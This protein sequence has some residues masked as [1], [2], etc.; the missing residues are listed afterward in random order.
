[1]NIIRLYRFLGSIQVDKQ[2]DNLYFVYISFIVYI[3][4]ILWFYKSLYISCMFSISIIFFR[5]SLPTNSCSITEFT[6]ELESQIPNNNGA[7]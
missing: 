2:V 3:I 7:A 6:Y 4:V 5:F 1:M